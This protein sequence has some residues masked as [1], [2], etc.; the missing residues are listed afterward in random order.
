VHGKKDSIFPVENSILM[1]EKIKNSKLVLLE[2]ADHIVVL[3]NF[4][5]VSDAIEEFAEENQS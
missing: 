3:N 2:K 4:I 1:A 5:E